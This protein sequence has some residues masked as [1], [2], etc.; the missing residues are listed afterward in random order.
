MV[1]VGCFVGTSFSVSVV[2]VSP[3][4]LLVPLRSNTTRDD[5]FM[6]SCVVRVTVRLLLSLM[7]NAGVS[8][9]IAPAAADGAS[10]IPTVKAATPATDTAATRRRR[11]MFMVPPEW[12]CVRLTAETPQSSQW[13]A[14]QL[15]NRRHGDRSSALPTIATNLLAVPIASGQQG[16]RRDGGERINGCRWFCCSAAC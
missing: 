7:P 5:G 14:A 9:V 2:M 16:R 8:F 4:P 6:R 12:F 1:T 3:S 10:A 13:L 15:A 11:A